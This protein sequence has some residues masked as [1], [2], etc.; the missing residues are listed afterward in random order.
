MGLAGDQ[1]MRMTSRVRSTSSLRIASAAVVSEV[2]GPR[3]GHHISVPP[4]QEVIGDT[5]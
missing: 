4:D 1:P 5:R 3:A 2:V